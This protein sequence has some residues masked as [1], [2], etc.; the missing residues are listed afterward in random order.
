LSVDLSWE[1][2]AGDQ[3]QPTRPGNPALDR[4]AGDNPMGVALALGERLVTAKSEARTLQIPVSMG[5][6]MHLTVT[7]GGHG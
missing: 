2:R 3:S 4:V 6:V 1:L 7:D 5:T